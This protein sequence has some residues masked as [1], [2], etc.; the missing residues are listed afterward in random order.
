VNHRKKFNPIFDWSQE[1][2][3]HRL[4]I[5]EKE[6]SIK[7]GMF[8]LIATIFAGGVGLGAIQHIGLDA[9]LDCKA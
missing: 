7:Y 8:Q 5:L 6:L 2:F 9:A 4:A 1:K 3:Q